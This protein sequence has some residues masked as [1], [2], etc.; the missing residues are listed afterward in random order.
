MTPRRYTFI[1]ADRR[2]GKMLRSTINIRPALVTLVILAALP[3]LIGQAIALK[4]SLDTASVVA[5]SQTFERENAKFRSLSQALSGKIGQLQTVIVDVGAR[6][7]L[8]PA[9]SSSME[10]LPSL[11]KA[12]AMGMGTAHQTTALG[13]QRK[14]TSLS[15]PEETFIWLHM[16]LDGLESQIDIV[17]T[18][19]AQRN[20]LAQATPTLWPTRGWLSSTMGRRKDP[21]TGSPDFHSGIDIAAMRGRS[22]Y[23]TASG[24]VIA[25]GAQ[26][27]YGK[28]IVINHGFGLETRYGHLLG[29]TVK[30]GDWVERGDQI[31]QMGNTG[32]TTGYHLHYE[33]LANGQILNPLRLLTQ[34]AP[35]EK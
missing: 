19:V 35:L 28:R 30:K 9:V 32:R 31:G 3:I 15:T 29:Y 5:K 12:Q 1:I 18:A 25:V 10:R 6:S 17:S 7:Q 11:I 16:L 34:Q 20:E 4:A 27:N 14:W 22:I 8:D 24:E 21:F 33:V 13:K 26:G 2:S 23:A